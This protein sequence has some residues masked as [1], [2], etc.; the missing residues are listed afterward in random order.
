MGKSP[1]FVVTALLAMAAAMGADAGGQ[2]RPQSRVSGTFNDY[3]WVEVGAGAGA[4][5]V[6]GEWTAQVGVSSGKGEF[7]ASLLGVRS[8]LWVLQTSADPANPA[9]RTPHTHHVGLHDAEVSVIPNGVRLTGAA[10]ITTNGAVAL[11]SGSSVQVDITGGD[12]I[13]FSNIKLTFL[14]AA[15]EHFGP[16]P[17][18]GIVVFGR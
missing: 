15:T 1:R 12:A 4:W 3:V 14:G 11:F 5:Q 10:V 16:Q 8:D 17:Y 6:T 18:D 7:V 9:L 13:R 2:E